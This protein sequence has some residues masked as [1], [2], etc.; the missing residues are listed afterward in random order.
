MAART[1]HSS[2]ASCSLA[3]RPERH[4]TRRASAQATASARRHPDQ[5]QVES[6]GSLCDATGSFLLV[7]GAFY[8]LDGHAFRGAADVWSG[9][10][11]CGGGVTTL[12]PAGERTTAIGSIRHE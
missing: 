7:E 5:R 3:A 9:E 1:R 8:F 12:A 4:K 10:G 6:R 11:S 2:S